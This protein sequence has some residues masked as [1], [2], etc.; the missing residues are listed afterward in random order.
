MNRRERQKYLEQYEEEERE[1]REQKRLSRQNGSE[2]E[3][4][5]QTE[6]RI[7]PEVDAHVLQASTSSS[8]PSPPKSVTEIIQKELD[9]NQFRGE[10]WGNVAGEVTERDACSREQERG[11]GEEESVS[12]SSSFVLRNGKL[13][14]SDGQKRARAPF[15]DTGMFLP[16]TFLR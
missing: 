1:E 7:A 15:N 14:N 2:V 5:L 12:A 13:V 4:Y 8:S 9:H 16:T 6:E 11:E 10:G 3:G